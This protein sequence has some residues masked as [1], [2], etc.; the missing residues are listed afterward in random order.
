M[1]LAPIFRFH[2][3]GVVHQ[4]LSNVLA[5]H[6]DER[7]SVFGP[8]LQLLLLRL[9]VAFGLL[10]WSIFLFEVIN[11]LQTSI[12]NTSQRQI[13]KINGNI[14]LIVEKSFGGEVSQLCARQKHLPNQKRCSAL[15]E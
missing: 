6:I 4:C 1:C 13:H 2:G 11:Y 7:V 3:D 12:V 8:Q 14:M 15:A 10:P 5:A 9:E